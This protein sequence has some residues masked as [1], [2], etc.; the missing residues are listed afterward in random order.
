MHLIVLKALKAVVVE[1]IFLCV[2]TDGMTLVDN[3]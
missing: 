3:Q 1:A 2:T